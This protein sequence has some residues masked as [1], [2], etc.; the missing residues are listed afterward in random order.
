[1]ATVELGSGWVPELLRRFALSYGKVP[2]LFGRDPVDTFREHVWVTP[3]Q[4]D[5]VGSLVDLIGADHVLFGSD[6]PHPEGMY[7][8]KAFLE[9]IAE[10]SPT[11]QDLI[12][13]KNLFA[14]LGIG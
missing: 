3:F 4:E 12:M 8:P 9:D 1:V 6:W 11:D 5:Y 13:G 14:L 7:E 2:Q 10:L